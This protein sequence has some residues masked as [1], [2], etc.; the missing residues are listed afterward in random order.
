MEPPAAAAGR[1]QPPHPPPRGLAPL[2]LAAG[3]GLGDRGTLSL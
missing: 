3:P 2:D 1:Q